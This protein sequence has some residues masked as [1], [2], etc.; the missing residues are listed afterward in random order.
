MYPAGL[1]SIPVMSSPIAPP[2]VI[3]ECPPPPH[4]KKE[5]KKLSGSHNPANL[6]FPQGPGALLG[7]W[8]KHSGKALEPL[9]RSLGRPPARRQRKHL[10]EPMSSEC[11]NS[12]QDT[13][14]AALVRASLCETPPQRVPSTRSGSF[15]KTKPQNQTWWSSHCPGPSGGGGKRPPH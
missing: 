12:R 14:S 10:L 11:S 2:G 6:S 3:P 1:S 13:S 9:S 4:Q 8:N 7:V 15:P 5:K